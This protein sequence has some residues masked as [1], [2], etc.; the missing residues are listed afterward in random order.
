M[1]PPLSSRSTSSLNQSQPRATADNENLKQFSIRASTLGSSYQ[2]ENRN[3]ET[4]PNQSDRPEEGLGEQNP[5]PEAHSREMNQQHPQQGQTAL[6]RDDGSV[7]VDRVTRNVGDFFRKLT[8][9]FGRHPEI[10]REFVAMLESGGP[11]RNLLP[12]ISNLFRTAPD[13]VQ[14][15][16]ANT[17]SFDQR[18]RM[19]Q[20]R[21]RQHHTQP[22]PTPLTH[23]APQATPHVP[24]DSGNAGSSRNNTD[25]S[26]N[27]ND[28]DS[29]IGSDSDS[30][31][32][33]SDGYNSADS[34]GD[35]DEDGIKYGPMYDARRDAMDFVADVEPDESQR[36]EIQKLLT[37][38]EIEVPKEQRKNTPAA[39]SCKLM[40]HQKVSLSWMIKQE[41]DQH[42]KGGLLADTMGLGKT[43]QA[44]ALILERPSSDRFR[45]TTLVVA[46]LSL[47]K[48][49]E[50]EIRTK[51]K[52]RHQ[53]KTIIYHG[54]SRR[55]MTVTKLLSYDV[56]LTTYGIIRSEYG[57]KRKNGRPIVM[58]QDAHFYR[59]ILDEAHNIKNRLSKSSIAA[60]HIKATYR[61]CMTGTPFMNRINEFFSL[62]RFLRIKP[63]NEWALFSHGIEKPLKSL[64]ENFQGA[65][66][67]KLQAV[68][69]SITLRR[70]KTSMLDGQ[71]ILR[72]P[73]LTKVEAMT[74]FNK[75]QKA[76]Y[77]ALETKQQ[78]KINE[79]MKAGTIMKKYS[80]I[81]VLLLRLRQTCC[82]PHL[83]KDFGIPEG[84]QLSADEMRELAEKLNKDV[85]KKL[86][87]QTEFKC[88]VCDE[89]TANPLIVYPC[90]HPIC[91]ACFSA[92]MEVKNPLSEDHIPC[93]YRPDCRSEIA[94]DNV[95]CHCYFMEV[96]MPEEYGGDAGEHEL[97]EEAD[98]FESIDDDDDVDARGNLKGF[99][100]SE[101]EDDYYDDIKD[102][103]V[104]EEVKQ[105]VKEEDDLE[106]RDANGGG[107][108]MGVKP[109]SPSIPRGEKLS[110]L[111]K[112]AFAEEKLA[113]DDS[114]NDS[115][116]SLDDI[117]RSRVKNKEP[118]KDERKQ[119][120]RDI[121]PDSILDIGLSAKK[122]G[123]KGKRGRPSGKE[124]F[125]SR[126]KSKGNDGTGLKRR[127]EKKN[128]FVSLAALKKASSGNPIAKANYLQRLRKDW[129]PSAKIER[130]M[131]LL[132]D[133]RAKDPKAKT[134]IFSLWTSFLDLL[135]IPI[136]DGGFRYTRY[137]GTMQHHDRDM[138]VKAFMDPQG[139]MQIM[140]VSLTA[141]NTGLNLTAAT[142]VIILEPFWNPFVEEQA[143]D[144]AHR[145]GQKKEVTVHRLLIE[146]TVED[147]IRALQEKKRGLVNAALSE[148]GAQG[149]SRLTLSELKGLF[150]LK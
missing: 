149:V 45:R 144:R 101:S 95:I 124:V 50:R 61:W 76:F 64:D 15:F 146:N 18:E 80:Y 141:G 48:Q 32:D 100:V 109:K 70:T 3:S 47:L 14:D 107:P 5:S 30:G 133:I 91:S 139:D 102:D 137:D 104:K 69:R 93:D 86:K 11:A 35:C 128:K 68:F 92:L 136:H 147:R 78:L 7:N 39:M 85:V 118:V 108:S 27:M 98:G 25:T 83:I 49:W 42:K 59:V 52:P 84:A 6:N 79:F 41:E 111:S 99:V 55:G 135:E 9:R 123:A 114:D 81:L 57:P 1:A 140:M 63:Y 148:E 89:M 73:E 103:K 12:S 90:G 4:Q 62:L 119:I 129:V 58:A 96:H 65:A 97:E 34:L 142:Q 74:T 54:P 72:L 132:Q 40:E 115:L 121:S 38:P 112:D 143:I 67:Q 131:E 66:M 94:P 37:M 29:T 117:F 44:L 127:K 82:H 10:I 110:D 134:L 17:D 88:P 75:E 33:S 20:L 126:K 130:T 60:A 24:N 122:S 19:R 145:I 106:D 22:S 51:V 8:Y 56:V 16:E 43:I 36:K 138:A 31:P 116:P 53:L 71:P 120:K 77:D 87:E 26:R 105:E 2:T 46:P 23:T 113:Q 150:G 13:L 21:A 125:R 28:D